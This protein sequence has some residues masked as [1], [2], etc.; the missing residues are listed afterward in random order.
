[1]QSIQMQTYR[2]FVTKTAE[3]ELDEYFDYIALDSIS[4]AIAWHTNIYD[5]IETLSKMAARCL[6]ADESAFLAFDV[7]CLLVVD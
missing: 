3:F 1:M 5:K 6:I 7:H 4:N 2:V